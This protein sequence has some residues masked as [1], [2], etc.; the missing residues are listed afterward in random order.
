LEKDKYMGEEFGWM[1]EGIKVG[2][3]A[4]WTRFALFAFESQLALV[5]IKNPAQCAG[6]FW[7]PG[8]DSNQHTLAS[9]AT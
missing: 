1:N 8:L 3:P 9:A 6:L 4:V 7:C 2:L 5:Q